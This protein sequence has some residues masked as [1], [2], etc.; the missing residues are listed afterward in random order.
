MMNLESLQ[1]KGEQQNRIG[2]QS[3]QG[4]IQD[5]RILILDFGPPWR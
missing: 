3:A 2:P 5:W 4:L 1:T